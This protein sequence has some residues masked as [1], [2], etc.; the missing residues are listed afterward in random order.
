MVERILANDCFG[1][2]SI[3]LKSS[4]V[5]IPGPTRSDAFAMRRT[6]LYLRMIG[7]AAAG[8]GAAFAIDSVSQALQPSGRFC[9]SNSLKPFRLM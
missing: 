6:T 3:K 7:L 8:S 1:S 9:A 2:G 4:L 5:P